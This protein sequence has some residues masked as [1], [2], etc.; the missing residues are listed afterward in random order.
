MEVP[1]VKVRINEQNTKEKPA[2]LFVFELRHLLSKGNVC[3]KNRNRK[4]LF[5]KKRVRVENVKKRWPKKNGRK[6]HF[7]CHLNVV[8]L[9]VFLQKTNTDFLELS[10]AQKSA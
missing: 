5:V 1:S 4:N 2:F 9:A 7:I 10:C 3:Q 6:N 8:Y